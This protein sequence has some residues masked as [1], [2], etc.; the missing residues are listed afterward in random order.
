MFLQSME[1][2]QN[3]CFVEEDGECHEAKYDDYEFDED[4]YEILQ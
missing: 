2:G 4:K 3:L 1:E